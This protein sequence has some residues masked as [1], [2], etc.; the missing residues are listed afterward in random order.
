MKTCKTAWRILRAN[1]PLLLGCLLG[2]CLIAGMLAM[3]VSQSYED[4]SVT[5]YMPPRASVA[6]IDRDSVSGHSAGTAIRSYLEQ[7]ATIVKVEDTTDDIQ[8]AL[9]SGYADLVVIVPQ[10]YADDFLAASRNGAAQA[11][12]TQNSAMPAIQFASNDDVS[13][14]SAATTLL[15]T[16]I[17]GFVGS[18]RTALASGV[19]DT[20]DDAFA[21]VLDASHDNA[22]PAITV[23]SADGNGTASDANDDNA[24]RSSSATSASSLVFLGA[25]TS[26]IY[27]LILTIAFGVTFV[28]TAFQTPATMR[29]LRASA[30]PAH[31]IAL[32]VLAVC[33]GIG[34]VAW[35]CC[36]L[37]ALAFSASADGGL[38]AINPASLAM[39]VVSMLTFALMTVCFGFLLGQFGISAPAANGIINTVGLA[40]AFLSGAWLPQWLMP[41]G[42][43]AVAKLLPGW[44]YVAAIYDSFGGQGV[45]DDAPRVSSWASS[46]ALLLLYSAVFICVGL[47]VNRLRVK[48]T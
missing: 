3:N 48:R 8:D 42:V 31:R 24:S 4:T 10:G 12:A 34:I 29:R 36:L 17:S 44:W 38:A 2:L 13:A 15:E 7:S 45:M 37:I 30:A 25:T 26:M 23:Q 41:A 19:C 27:S 32:G 9:T 22:T 14:P 16:Q 18:A 35:L 33:C 46:T 39:A 1:L 43:T 11:G 47:A 21:T 20:T 6:I 5:E 40:S 28:I